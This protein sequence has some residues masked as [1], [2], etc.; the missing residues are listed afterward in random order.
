MDDDPNHLSSYDQCST[1]D[2]EG[3]RL[4]DKKKVVFKDEI[5]ETLL[6][7]YNKFNMEDNEI[8]KFGLLVSPLAIILAFYTLVSSSISCFIAF[9]AFTISIV[10]ICF[11]G[12]MLCDI[13]K[14]DIGPKGMQEIAEVIREGSEGFFIT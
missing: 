14:K 12:F 4:S 7:Y 1:D 11:S 13:L 6:S 10:F 8:L 3:E 2:F 5:S 9:S